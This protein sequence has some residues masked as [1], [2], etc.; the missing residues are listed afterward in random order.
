MDGGLKSHDL[1]FLKEF[2]RFL[3]KRP[4]TVKKFTIL[5]RKFSPPHRSALFCSNLVKFVRLE[6]VEIVR[7]LP[8]KK[9]RIS[10]AP[11]TAAT[12]RIALKICQVQP[13]RM[14]SQCSRFHANQF[15]FGGVIPEHVNT[16]FAPL[17][18]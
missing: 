5:L 7:Y 12:A 17:I 4:L 6:I 9:N 1:E 3:E 13:P 15:T 10:A 18:P 2:L 8:D 11:Q 14:Y 16:V